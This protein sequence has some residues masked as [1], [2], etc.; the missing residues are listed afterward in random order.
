MR[1]DEKKVSIIVNCYNG[2]KYLKNC[3]DSIKKQSYRNYELI[4]WDNK[5]QDNSKEIFLNFID[6]ARFKYF[7]SDKHTTLY[8][9]RNLAIE[10]TSGD[11]I[12]FLD[13]DD[14]WVEDYLSNRIKIFNEKED[15]IFSFSNCYHYFQRKK[16][17]KV[18]TKTIIP[19]GN[20]FDFS[21]QRT[22]TTRITNGFFI[23]VRKQSSR[24]NVGKKRTFS[25]AGTDSNRASNFRPV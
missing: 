1:L 21:R 6:D 16:K 11:Y 7:E 4:F 23:H 20:I 2:S 18:F 24:L 9:A 19:S 5:S 3:L 14:W 22:V 12:A 17:K 15:H 10:K 8:E 13:T 25:I